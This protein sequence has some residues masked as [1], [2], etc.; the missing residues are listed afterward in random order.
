MV[1]VSVVNDSASGEMLQAM[2]EDEVSVSSSLMTTDGGIDVETMMFNLVQTSLRNDHGD[3][4]ATAAKDMSR[5]IFAASLARTTTI[6]GQRVYTTQR[7]DSLA[8]IALQFYENPAAY[9]RILEANRVTLQSPEQIQIGQRLI[10][11]V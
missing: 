3:T 11:P 8:Y 10:I 2:A 9:N 7:G 5:K 6:G 1:N 4:G